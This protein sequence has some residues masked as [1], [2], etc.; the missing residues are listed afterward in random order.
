MSI[1]KSFFR[2]NF[3]H[4]CP[5]IGADRGLTVLFGDVGVC[6]IKWSTNVSIAHEG[7]GLNDA[8]VQRQCRLWLASSIVCGRGAF[9]CD[10]LKDLNGLFIVIVRI[11]TLFK[12]AHFARLTVSAIVIVIEHILIHQDGSNVILMCLLV[13]QQGNLI[14]VF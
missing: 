14:Q 12:N 7:F 10:V 4:F 9:R 2:C 5:E 6:A 11:V 1:R 3:A 13:N 8:R